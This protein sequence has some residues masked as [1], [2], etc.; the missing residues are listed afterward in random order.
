MGLETSWAEPPR[1]HLLMAWSLTLFPLD[2]MLKIEKRSDENKRPKTN[3]ESHVV[4]RSE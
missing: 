4:Q 1:G 3:G 2:L